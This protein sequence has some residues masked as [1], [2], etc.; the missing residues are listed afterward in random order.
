MVHKAR[1][2]FQPTVVV[3]APNAISVG[4][5]AWGAVLVVAPQPKAT[6][7]YAEFQFDEHSGLLSVSG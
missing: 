4:R 6:Y 3:V 5:W 1:P 7:L 2:D